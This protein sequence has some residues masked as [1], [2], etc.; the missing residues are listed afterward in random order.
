MR[1]DRDGNVVAAD[2]ALTRQEALL[3]LTRWGARFISAEDSLGSIVTGHYA[4][5]VVFDGDIMAVPIERIDSIKPVLTMV[6]GRIAF[7]RSTPKREQV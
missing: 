6:G 2:E 1:V 4:D 7:E 5:L 3:A